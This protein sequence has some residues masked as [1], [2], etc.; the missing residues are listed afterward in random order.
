MKAS[1]IV[2]AFV[3]AVLFGQVKDL[4]TGQALTGVTITIG[5]HTATTDSH[6]KYRMTGLAPGDYTLSAS[7]DDVPPQHKDVTVKS[8]QTEFDFKLCSTTLDYGCGGVG[9]G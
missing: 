3:A 2:A 1:A 7:S 9:P 8:P 5:S 4:T 6:G